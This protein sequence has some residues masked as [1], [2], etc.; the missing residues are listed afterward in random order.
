MVSGTR[1]R[2]CE[3]GYDGNPLNLLLSTGTGE[4]ESCLDADAEQR[5][6]IG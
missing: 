5:G 2:N 6:A 3:W 4:L 1:V